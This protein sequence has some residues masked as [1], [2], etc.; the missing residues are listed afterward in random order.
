MGFPRA[1]LRC[2]LRRI[3][4]NAWAY[5]ISMCA[6]WGADAAARLAEAQWPNKGIPLYYRRSRK[7]G[8]H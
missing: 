7:G 4:C 5:V 3:V 2:S 8:E 6:R 1:Q